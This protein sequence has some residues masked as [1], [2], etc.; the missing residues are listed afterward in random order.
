MQARLRFALA[1]S[2]K[3]IAL[4]LELLLVQSLEALDGGEG[5]GDTGGHLG[6]PEELAVSPQTLPHTPLVVAID[7]LHLAG[8]GD[9]HLPARSVGEATEVGG[10]TL[11]LLDT[12][13]EG[14]GAEFR[15]GGE[16]VHRGH[17]CVDRRMPNR[18]RK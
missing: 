7:S 8:E 18:L 1:E 17:S 6:R 11:D 16:R 3:G 12:L 5:I 10:R 14:L 4:V 15:G 13:G 2:V 9:Q